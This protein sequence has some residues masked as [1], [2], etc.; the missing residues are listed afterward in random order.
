[1]ATAID[2]ID[3]G[4]VVYKICATAEDELHQTRSLACALAI[5]STVLVP[6]LN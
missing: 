3:Y 1:M 2:L 5:L 4:Y 6:T